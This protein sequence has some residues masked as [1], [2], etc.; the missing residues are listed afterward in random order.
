[1]APLKH[2]KPEKEVTDNGCPKKMSLLSY[3]LCENLHNKYKLYISFNIK[4][5]L[6]PSDFQFAEF[7]GEFA[8]STWIFAE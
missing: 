5:Q 3:D 6:E 7:Q 1:L 2:E 8:E 4:S